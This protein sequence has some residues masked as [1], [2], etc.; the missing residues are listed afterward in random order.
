[1]LIE[2]ESDDSI[3]KLVDFG[4]SKVFKETRKM[5]QISGTPY[6]IAPEVI[7]QSYSEKCDEW[8]C[9]VILY[10]LLCGYPP[11]NG[12]TKQE[13]MDK[14][15]KGK[16]TFQ[17]PEWTNITYDAKNLILKLLHYDPNQRISAKEALQDKWIQ[18][19]NMKYNF[20][21]I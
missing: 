21:K 12:N 19:L 6:Y 1:M 5:T 2:N 11:F 13:I 17:G 9:G 20:D 15:L 14:V 3:I 18:K 16:I 8:S 10:L 7:S 4:T